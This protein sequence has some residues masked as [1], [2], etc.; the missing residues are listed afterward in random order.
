MRKAQKQRL[1]LYS[2]IIAALLFQVLAWSYL[3]LRQG[4]TQTTPS[5][6]GAYSGLG[7]AWALEKRVSLHRRYLL[8]LCVGVAMG[9]LL[10][11][12]L[13]GPF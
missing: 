8:G 9:S 4:L 3:I 2:I 11:R 1:G 12:L 7:T 5:I 6:V 13:V 10:Y